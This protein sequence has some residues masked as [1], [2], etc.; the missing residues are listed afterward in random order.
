MGVN[1]VLLLIAGARAIGAEVVVT[2]VTTCR[3][4]RIGRAMRAAAR[5]RR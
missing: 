4:S 1:D 2:V 3:G 5:G